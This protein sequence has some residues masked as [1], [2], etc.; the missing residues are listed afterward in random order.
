MKKLMAICLCICVLMGLTA[1]GGSKI[2]GKWKYSLGDDSSVVEFRGTNT[3]IW[4]LKSSD[5][6]E[7]VTGTYYY[8][9]ER[10]EVT[11]TLPEFG[12]RTFDVTL[13]IPQIDFMNLP[14][15]R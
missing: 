15:R 5:G 13:S 2:L 8:D 9:E 10:E 4:T 12:T 3:V 14:H 7:T 11:V 6:E 1:C